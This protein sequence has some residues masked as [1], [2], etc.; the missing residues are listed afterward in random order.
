MELRGSNAAEGFA[1]LVTG[2]CPD[3]ALSGALESWLALCGRTR[4][5]P[6]P[7]AD[8]FTN[9]TL[10]LFERA[11]WHRIRSVADKHPDTD[12]ILRLAGR[13][14]A[15]PAPDFAATADG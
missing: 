1:D 7:A 13:N 11:V 14:L 15:P 9:A 2:L 5:E 6:T 4:A 8:H 12:E 10:A 3:G